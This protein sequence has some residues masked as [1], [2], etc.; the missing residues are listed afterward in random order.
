MMTPMTILEANRPASCTNSVRTVSQ[1]LIVAR[2][3]RSTDFS[4]RH[5]PE[6]TDPHGSRGHRECVLAHRGRNG[7]STVDARNVGAL[8]AHRVADC[9]HPGPATDVPRMASQRADGA[10]TVEYSVPR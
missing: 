2:Q 3:R 5:G 7:S 4:H 10:G 6:R 1:A 8:N 9:N